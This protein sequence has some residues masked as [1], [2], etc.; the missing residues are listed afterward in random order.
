MS[1]PSFIISSA[2]ISVIFML[3]R[4]LAILSASFSASEMMEPSGD[5]EASE[6]EMGEDVHDS[7]DS[8]SDFGDED[9]LDKDSVL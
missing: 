7:D 4:S 3:S 2:W 6:M 8:V 1:T 5:S 9:L